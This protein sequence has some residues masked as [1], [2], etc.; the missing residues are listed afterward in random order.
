MRD[1]DSR[2]S[3]SFTG[4]GE[5]ALFRFDHSIFTILEPSGNGWPL[6]GMPLR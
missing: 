5:T 6:P 3:G 1:T 4:Y 2:V